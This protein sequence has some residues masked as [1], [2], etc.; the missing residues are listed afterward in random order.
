MKAKTN[1]YFIQLAYNGTRFH[2]WQVQPNA[3]SVQEVLTNAISIILKEQVEVVGAGRTDTGV[4]ASF[5]VAHF[6]VEQELTDIAQLCRKLNR[7]LN[8]DVQV[9]Q[10]FEVDGEMHAR[11]SATYRTYHYYLSNS[12]HPF[13]QE[14]TAYYP[15]T[16]DLEL[17]NKAA[18]VL[19]DYNDF[20]SFSKLHTDVKTNNCN[21]F[22]AE[23]HEE[24]G[25]L[26]FEISA[27]RFLRN[28]VR[29]IVGTLMEVG[30]HKISVADLRQIIEKRD[31]CAAGASVLAKGLF[32]TDIG[33]PE[34]VNSSLKR[35]NL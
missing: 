8:H 19:F 29:A 31:R 35:T 13:R 23:W 11:F 22:K 32:L 7:F 20:T 10:L 16:F 15:Q 5:F 30:K 1:R 24:K 2:G 6:D 9:I 12:K 34:P 25:L 27:D 3:I 33:Y 14:F 18:K 17:M 21:I 4:H 28:M 26:V